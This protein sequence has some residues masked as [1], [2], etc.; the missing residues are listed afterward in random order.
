MISSGSP[1]KSPE[2]RFVWLQEDVTKL[3]VGGLLPEHH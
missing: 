3:G 2:C 1:R